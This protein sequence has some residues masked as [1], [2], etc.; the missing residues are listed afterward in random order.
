MRCP[1]ANDIS[2]GAFYLLVIGD[3]NIF[4]LCFLKHIYESN[5]RILVYAIQLFNG[6]AATEI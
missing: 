5:V 1:E 2:S 4:F 6:F 3:K